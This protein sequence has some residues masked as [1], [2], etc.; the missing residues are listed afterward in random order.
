MRM[1]ENQ[2]EVEQVETAEVS[3]SD[4]DDARKAAALEA[5]SQV[6]P[7]DTSE[8]SEPSTDPDEIAD[9]V[10]GRKRRE[11][12][13]QKAMDE[14]DAAIAEEFGEGHEPKPKV[15]VAT[16]TEFEEKAKKL[17]K[18]LERRD[19]QITQKQAAA[20]DLAQQQAMLQQ[21]QQ[22]IQQERQRI[23]QERAYLDLLRKDPARAIRES[24]LR[25]EEFLLSLAEEDT[26]ESRLR[27]RVQEQE[28]ELARIRNW[29]E[30]QEQERVNY[31]RKAQE[32]QQEHHRS[33][34]LQQFTSLAL[35]P[36]VSPHLASMYED[37]PSALV[38]EGDKI[39]YQYRQETGQE[40]GIDDIVTL[41]EYRAQQRYNRVAG[42]KRASEPSKAAPSPVAT[43]PQPVAKPRTITAD[44]ASERRL[45][46]RDLLDL[47]DDERREHAIRVAN[48]VQRKSK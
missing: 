13:R 19:T 29:R 33:T 3:E 6:E 12:P 14:A 41:L 24:G 31:L 34:V 43:K 30:Q 27:K 28:D 47:S 21:Q 45:S 25:P 9:D 15:E 23:E 20:R 11:D 48:A 37:D 26:P 35:N 32:E 18:L 4:A 42:K 22:Q 46:P 39:A 36:E 16:G 7:E 44:V 38:F 5:L 10:L 40:L 8:E 17:Q 1:E 2:S